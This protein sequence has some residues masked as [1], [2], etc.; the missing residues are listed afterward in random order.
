[1]CGVRLRT[2][3]HAAGGTPVRRCRTQPGTGSVL[4]RTGDRLAGPPP[5]DDHAVRPRHALVGLVRHKL[6]DVP[7]NLT[8]PAV[9]RLTAHP[10][11]GPRWK[12]REGAVHAQAFAAARPTVDHDDQ[13]EII[14]EFC[15]FEG[16]MGIPPPT[17]E[18]GANSL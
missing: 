11:V 12:T 17:T 9:R 13:H 5:N 10:G 2:R 16:Q 4:L 6:L 7:G 3:T 8:G 14:A 18:H 1:M 15:A